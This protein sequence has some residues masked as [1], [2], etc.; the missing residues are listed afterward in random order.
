LKTLN[1]GQLSWIGGVD[2]ELKDAAFKRT[3]TSSGM[4]D[5]NFY[6]SIK[7]KEILFFTGLNGCIKELLL[8]RN[9]ISVQ[10]DLEPLIMRRKKVCCHIIFKIIRVIQTEILLG[11]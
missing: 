6:L 5:R 4:M 3:G 2:T 1:I 9:I 10:S 8:S 7:T 11:C